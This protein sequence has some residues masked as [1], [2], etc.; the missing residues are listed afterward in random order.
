MPRKSSTSAQD[1]LSAIAAALNVDTGELARIV[2]EQ[3]KD[4]SATRSTRKKVTRSS[5]A[6]TTAARKTTTKT[7]RE[8]T[9]NEAWK[10]QEPT[11]RQLWK[12]RQL[13]CPAQK[14]AKMDKYEMA[15]WIGAHV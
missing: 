4:D 6:K 8:F 2:A 12:A 1:V 3:Q 10:G 7:P 5:G 13:K 9:L 15:E 14:L 11:A